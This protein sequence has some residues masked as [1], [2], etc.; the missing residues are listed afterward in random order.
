MCTLGARSWRTASPAAVLLLALL[1][2]LALAACGDSAGSPSSSPSATPA[3]TTS[4]AAASPSA[5]P[6]PAPGVP[7]TIAFS[8]SDSLGTRDDIYVV[9]SDGTGLELVA[10]G[11]ETANEHPSWS[12]DGSRIVYHSGSGELPTYTIWAVDADGS[13]RTR[14]T[15]GSVRGLWPSWSPD[16][17]KI[18]FTRYLPGSGSTVIA[19]MDADGGHLRNL[20]RVGH[21]DT[22][23]TWATAGSVMFLRDWDVYSVDL[24]TGRVTRETKMGFVGDYALSPNGGSMAICDAESSRVVVGAVDGAATPVTLVDL[25]SDPV[26]LGSRSSP[27]WRQDGTALVMATSASGVDFASGSGLYVVNA[28]GSGLSRVPG[29]NCAFDPAW[30]PE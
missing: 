9:N 11:P 7:G 14:L 19:V 18:A 30:R 15:G 17:A 8:M 16:G 24:D 2:T 13:N 23:A 26:D 5:T 4:A 3:A 1:A 21:D 20:T 10:D 22:F 6:L 25:M 12:P 29:V 27:S 28:D